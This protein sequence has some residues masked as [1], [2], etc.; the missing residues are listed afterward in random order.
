[1]LDALKGAPLDYKNRESGEVQTRY[2]DNTAEKNQADSVAGSVAYLKAQYRFRVIVASGFYYKSDKPSVKITI[3][4]EQFIQR[5]V[6]EQ[7]HQTE[8]D[9]IEENTLLYRIG[10][11]IAIRLKLSKL[12]EDK[13]NKA[14]QTTDF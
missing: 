10:R 2:V 13:T 5:D 9:S 3:Q 6:L 12:E 7:P 8:T 11:I 4:K 14:I 1:M